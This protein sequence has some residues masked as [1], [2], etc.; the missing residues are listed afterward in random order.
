M[1]VIVTARGV[2]EVEVVVELA[3]V[4]VDRV[5]VVEL[6]VV[7]VVPVEAEVG[8]PPMGRV[9]ADGPFCKTSK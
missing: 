7:V 2:V 9:G 4:V 3:N 5:V 1:T 8:I 6:L